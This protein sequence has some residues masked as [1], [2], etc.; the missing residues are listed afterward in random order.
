MNAERL[1]AIAISIKEEL[2]S[3][4]EVSL[5]GQLA[6]SLRQSVNEP[7]QV[8]ASQFRAQL[9]D[10]LAGAPS[11][12]FS[13]AWRQTLEELGA[14]DL[15]GTNLRDTVEG[16]FLRN[17]ITPASAA[18]ELEAISAE[19]G[20]LV[21]GLD[22]LLAG[23]GSFDIG[24]EELAPGEFEVGFLIPRAAVDSEL[25][26]LG[27]EF[28]ELKEILG[29]VQELATGTR[30]EVKVRTISSS[31]FQV[32]LAALPDVALVMSQIV[33]S[34]LSSYEKILRIREKYSGLKDEDDV[35]DEAL[36]GILGHANSVMAIDIQALAEKIV[37]EHGH[38]LRGEGRSHEVRMDVT[39]SLTAIAHRI[40]EGYSIEIRSYDLPEGEE[41]DEEPHDGVPP[42]AEKARRIVAER[43]PRLR[44][45]NLTGKPIL[46]QLT[47]GAEQADDDGELQADAPDGPPDPEI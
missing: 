46:R 14:A 35:P 10:V 9:G 41:D 36:E 28:V 37:E 6:Q 45:M 44:A 47:D 4:D 24:A 34:L 11:N 20:K 1:H 27:G 18:D 26:R 39:R 43:Q 38:R 15:L 33:E 2:T 17:E 40:D 8:Q 21:V 13:A 7:D 29:P 42:Q 23:L 31:G 19:L 3:T 30:D 5:V 25:E 22:S 16:I 32:F 12:G